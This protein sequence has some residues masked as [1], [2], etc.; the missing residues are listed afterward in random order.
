MAKSRL[1]T[2]SS[3]SPFPHDHATPLVTIQRSSRLFDLDL[4]AIWHY[5]ELL[6]FL[7]WRDVKVRYKQ[8]AIGAGW[9]I[10]QPVMNM[11]IF[12]VVFGGFAKIPSEGLPYPI[13][14]FTAL[15]PWNYFA[16]AISRSGGSL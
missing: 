13:F 14:A 8:T 2:S 9:A 16:Q 10:L 12:S 6:Y 4:L 7:T 15:L 5:R 11:V 3:T 1:M